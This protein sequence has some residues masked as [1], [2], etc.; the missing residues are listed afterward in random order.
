MPCLSPSCSLA[1]AGLAAAGLALATAPG[2]AA[3]SHPV[4]LTTPSAV[5][6]VANARHPHKNVNRA[7]D[8]GNS[9]GDDQIEKLNE[10]QLNQ[11]YHGQNP[12]PAGGATMAAPGQGMSPGMSSP[13]MAA[14]TH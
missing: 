13:G 7:N 5:Q 8:K 9:T 11:N 4:A 1:L 14:P 12:A 2:R 10:M 6:L 3:S